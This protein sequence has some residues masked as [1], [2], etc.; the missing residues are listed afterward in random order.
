MTGKAT[1][2]LVTVPLFGYPGERRPL[3]PDPGR[4]GPAAC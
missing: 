2:K 3:I 1:G 4:R